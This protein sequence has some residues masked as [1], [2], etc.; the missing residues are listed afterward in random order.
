MLSHC[1]CSLVATVIVSH[2]HYNNTELAFCEP[3]LEHTLAVSPNGPYA[4]FTPDTLLHLW[5]QQHQVLAMCKSCIQCGA[6]TFTK[7]SSVRPLPAGSQPLATPTFV[8]RQLPLKT[9]SVSSLLP[10]QLALN[11]QQLLH[12]CHGLL[13]ASGT[14]TPSLLLRPRVPRPLSPSSSSSSIADPTRYKVMSKLLCTKHCV[15][16]VTRNLFE[17]CSACVRDWPHESPWAMKGSSC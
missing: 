13:A 16:S 3:S 9:S 6:D 15:A 17:V 10:H 4:G 12:R 11:Q 5:T 2:C 14:P 8:Y 7:C 1:V